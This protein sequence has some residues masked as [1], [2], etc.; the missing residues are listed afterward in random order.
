ERLVVGVGHRFE[1]DT[2]GLEHDW[3]ERDHVRQRTCKVVPL[4]ERRTI[5]T[6]KGKS[7]RREVM[8]SRLQGTR[9]LV[10]SCM[11]AAAT[12]RAFAGQAWEVEVHGGGLIATN[13]TQG[14]IAIPPPSASVPLSPLQPSFTIE[15]VPSWFFGDG[16]A[17]LSGAL[18]PRLG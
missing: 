5:N 9:W 7:N 2:V 16:A 17:L 11:L 12:P 15:P 10:V 18:P 14:T 1:T 3:S 8:K 6:C 13:P 4:L